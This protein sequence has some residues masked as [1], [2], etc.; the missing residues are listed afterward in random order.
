MERLE[1]FGF[2]G[3]RSVWGDLQYIGP[4]GK[5]NLIA[6]QNNSGKSNVLRFV[7][8]IL[9][10]NPFTVP[11]GLDRPQG[12]DIDD[13]YRFA[14][15]RRISDEE[16]DEVVGRQ[17]GMH[18]AEC[19]KALAEVLDSCKRSDIDDDLVWFE[20]SASD[21]PTS[22]PQRSLSLATDHLRDRLNGQTLHQ[23]ALALTGRASSAHDNLTAIL[24]LF[25]PIHAL[26][27]VKSVDAFRQITSESTQDDSTTADNALYV[28]RGLIRSLQRLQS[29]DITRQ[30]DKSRFQAINRFVQQVLDDP[31]ASLD[32][33][34]DASAILVRRGDLTLPLEHLGTGVHQ[35]VILAVAATLLEG[36]LICM[37]EPEVHLHPLLQ[38]KLVRYLGDHTQNQYLI[39]THSAHMLDHERAQIFHAQHATAGT[40]ITSVGS[41]QQVADVC[42]DLGYRPSDLL[43]ANAVIWVEGPSDRVYLRRWI[44]LGDPSLIEGIHYSIMFYGGRLLNH[45][46]AEDQEVSD[47]ISL[48]RLNRHIAILIDS[49]KKTPQA[50][51]ND[52]KKRVEAEFEQPSY[53][54]FA[55]ITDGRTIE[56]YVP[57]LALRATFESLYPNSVLSY[58]D[59]KWSDP[60]AHEG[61]P[62]DVD[63]VRLAQ[64]LCAQEGVDWRGHRDL[65]KRIRQVVEFIHS[66]NGTLLGSDAVMSERGESG[67]AT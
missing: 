16:V 7:H 26:P 45:L 60:L 48:R 58:D 30:G 5:V 41:P 29:P 55:W 13:A 11:E 24:G 28:G 57:L 27:A 38:R 2:T 18:P 17:Q 49:D 15:A 52:T 20:Y 34:H 61:T 1:G 40:Q 14:I 35:V 64:A 31:S 9:G 47:F 21:D 67:A 66:A 43:Q 53:P 46:S 50:R 6:G 23:L 36:H 42:A 37:E 10:R 56:N 44:G 22:S 33:P 25:T 8:G 59:N 12:S 51:V 62:K 3:Y 54:G 4:M 39:A 19:K 65:K 63:K 32:I